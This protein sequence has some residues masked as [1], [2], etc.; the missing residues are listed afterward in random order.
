MA[1]FTPIYLSD[2]QFHTVYQSLSLKQIIWSAIN[3]LFKQSQQV[4]NLIVSSF[5]LCTFALV[6]IIWGM[7]IESRTMFATAWWT[8]YMGLNLA[9]T[10]L[11]TATSRLPSNNVYPYGYKRFEVIAVFTN[12]SLLL[13]AGIY[14]FFEAIETLLDEKV[15]VLDGSS[16][17]S[18]NLT[19]VVLALVGLLLHVIITIVFRES[20]V[21]N[22]DVMRGASLSLSVTHLVGPTL[23]F[24]VAVLPPADALLALGF[25]L[26]LWFI[27]IPLC[28]R[29]GRVLLQGRTKHLASFLET[30]TC[31]ISALQ[32]VVAIKNMHVWTLSPGVHVGTFVLEIAPSVDASTI[33]S[34]VTSILKHH[35]YYLTIQ[36]VPVSTSHEYSNN[37]RIHS[38]NI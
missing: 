19:Q 2:Q 6:Q 26:Y 4:R 12:G 9:V 8:L 38:Y 27:A 10:V 5:L 17:G 13:F 32:G 1:E 34:L 29:A 36:T 23:C 30:S 22:T 14:T 21:S 25:S 35:I 33:V 15:V 20:L 37:G 3:R 31:Q 28:W 18:E 7:S 24:I 11:V 16:S